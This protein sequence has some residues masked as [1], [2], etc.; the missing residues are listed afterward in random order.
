MWKTLLGLSE[1]RTQPQLTLLIS[2]Q[3]MSRGMAH[4]GT[5][6]RTRRTLAQHSQLFRI[7][8]KY[9]VARR[10]VGPSKRCQN[11]ENSNICDVMGKAQRVWHTVL[12]VK[13]SGCK[14]LV[15]VFRAVEFALAARFNIHRGEHGGPLTFPGTDLPA[16][17]RVVCQLIS[18]KVVRLAA[19]ASR[20]A[21]ARVYRHHSPNLKSRRSRLYNQ[22]VGSVTDDSVSVCKHEESTIAFGSVSPT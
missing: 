18:Q 14:W 15:N 6:P 2:S 9:G 4:D 16:E 12:P 10:I 3:E 7:S 11:K 8:R 17:W 20:A 1:Y 5:L 19:E 21:A 22:H 13:C